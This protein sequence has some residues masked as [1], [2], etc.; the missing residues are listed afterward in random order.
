VKVQEK[1]LL[2]RRKEEEKEAARGKEPRTQ[3]GMTRF[4]ETGDRNRAD[5]V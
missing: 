3:R 1:E 4:G 5:L 2:K